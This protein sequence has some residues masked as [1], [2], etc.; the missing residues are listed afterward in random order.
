MRIQ[1]FCVPLVAAFRHLVETSKGPSVV[2]SPPFCCDGEKLESHNVSLKGWHSEFWHPCFRMLVEN[3]FNCNSF[4]TIPIHPSKPE[5]FQN[6]DSM[7]FIFRCSKPR[8]MELA[9]V[10]A[11]LTREVPQLLETMY[12]GGPGVWMNGA[13][14]PC[15]SELWAR[16]GIEPQKRSTFLSEKLVKLKRGHLDQ[17]K[18]ARCKCS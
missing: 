2:R 17:P 15:I 9:A 5:T 8:T 12:L 1:S 16:Q 10:E 14:A 3:L 13:T 7:F 18:K 6:C 4:S 11:E